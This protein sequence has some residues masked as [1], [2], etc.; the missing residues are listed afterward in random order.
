MDYGSG[1]LVDML[2]HLDRL[3]LILQGKLKML[4]NL[5][6]SVFV[7]VSKLKLF[8]VHIQ[9]GDLTCFPTLLKASKQVTC[10]AL[11]K[12]TARSTTEKAT[13]YVPC[14]PI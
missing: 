1:L 5:V 3:N 4:P 9:K 12:Q 11:K 6:Q 14:R 7:F 2:C 10:A 13:D 8:K